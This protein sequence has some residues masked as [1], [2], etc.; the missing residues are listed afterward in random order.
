LKALWAQAR[1][2]LNVTT[3]IL[4]NRKY[5]ILLGELGNFGIASGA[6]SARMLDLGN[7]DIDRIKIANGMGVEAAQAEDCERLAD[8]LRQSLHRTGPFLI[9]L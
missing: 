4:A 2:R 1:E 7:P 3:I 6:A 9:E 8:L 5:A